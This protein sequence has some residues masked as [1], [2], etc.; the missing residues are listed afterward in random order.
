LILALKIIIGKE[1]GG[2]YIY[3]Y[4]YIYTMGDSG[5]GSLNE[6][7]IRQLGTNIK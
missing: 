6:R 4:I 1:A 2:L 3:I 7:Q 5:I